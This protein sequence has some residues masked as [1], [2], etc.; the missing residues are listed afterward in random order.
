[1]RETIE[2]ACATL[3]ATAATMLTGCGAEFNAYNGNVR[4][5]ARVGTV[6]GDASA[7]NVIFVSIDGK[8]SFGTWEAPTSKVR[9]L[10]GIHKFG[11]KPKDNDFRR[12]L[13]FGVTAGRE[14]LVLFEDG[15]FDV[16]EVTGRKINFVETRP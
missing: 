12:I 8:A 3:L 14:Y 1:M 4:D 10:P 6:R 7:G 16:E 2:L 11:V 15:S 5:V 13:R 9:V